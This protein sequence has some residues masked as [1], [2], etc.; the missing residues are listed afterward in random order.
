MNKILISYSEAARL[1]K[2]F[3]E[4][5][6]L[7]AIQVTQTRRW[8]VRNRAKISKTRAIQYRLFG[9]Y[10]RHIDDLGVLAAIGRFEG[11]I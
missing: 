6:S 7:E 1:R 2:S 9:R 3:A 5:R 4:I 11:P 10:G 8:I